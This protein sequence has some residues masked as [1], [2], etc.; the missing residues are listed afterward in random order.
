[1]FSLLGESLAG[2]LGFQDQGFLLPLALK[3][4][5][6]RVSVFLQYAGNIAENDLHLPSL[7]NV[8]I[9]FG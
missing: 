7:Y 8:D 6:H 4:I 3:I 2:A 1:M 5:F 9:I